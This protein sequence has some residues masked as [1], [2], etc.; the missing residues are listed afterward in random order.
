MWLKRFIR[1]KINEM[2]VR[3]IGISATQLQ[4]FLEEAET[5]Q[6]QNQLVVQRNSI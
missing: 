4:S 3:T 6:R 2:T 1:R 5:N